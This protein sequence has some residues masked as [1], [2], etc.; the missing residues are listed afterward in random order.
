MR[1]NTFGTILT[2]TTFGE[3]HGPAL[4]AVVDGCPAGIAL[5]EDDFRA[6]LARR[7]PGQSAIA[8]PRNE[9]D[10]PEIL[11]GV[12]E[13]RTLGTP[14]A[15]VVRNTDA[16][17]E[18]YSPVTDR[19]GHAGKVW[20]TKYGRRDWRGGGRASGRETLA[21]VIGGTV[22]G[23]I[24]PPA[25]RITAFVQS[26]GTIT[27][28]EI[29]DYLDHGIVDS[30]PTRCPDARAAASM[31]ADLEECKARGDSRGGTV[32]LRIDGVPAGLGEPVFYKAK[33]LLAAAML[34][35]GAVTGAAFGDAFAECSMP[36]MEFHSTMTANGLP[37]YAHGIQ[38][39]ITNGGR[40]DLRIAIKPVSA[41]GEPARSG[42]HDVCIAPR[43][44]PVAEAM[45]ALVLA[46][47]YLLTR[48]DKA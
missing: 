23:K 30:H 14:I 19:M 6:D 5:C 27:A 29:P 33:A 38:G 40:I 10:E 31:L 18:D 32:A 13:G 42:R 48:M 12:F 17:P 34:S 21:R 8:S 45:A 11:S 39:G 47:L 26:I 20:E 16:R 4:G 2:L 44:V 7:R 43:I 3:S 35:I 15:V 37:L 28:S 41:I 46:D 24:L 25:V 36:G 22:A 9:A 1:G